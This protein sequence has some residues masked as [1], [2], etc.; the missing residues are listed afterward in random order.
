MKSS[1]ET[2][3]SMSRMS[4]AAILLNSLK[5]IPVLAGMFDSISGSK[6]ISCSAD[7]IPKISLRLTDR[8]N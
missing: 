7:T 8:S 5:N 3:P 4:K 2:H 1:I 6:V